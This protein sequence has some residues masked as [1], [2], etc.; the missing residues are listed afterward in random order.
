MGLSG[1]LA[2]PEE[3]EDI[4]ENEETESS[5]FRD[6][7]VDCACDEPRKEVRCGREVCEVCAA[8]GTLGG[9]GVV[10]MWIGIDA[11]GVGEVS[12]GGMGDDAREWGVGDT[13]RG[14]GVV[15]REEGGVVVRSG[16]GL[17]CGGDSSS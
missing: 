10:G 11:E 16:I 12:R 14:V 4:E 13:V 17:D 7:V 15:G 2:D 3:R 8:G 6:P 5:S 1:G 9:T